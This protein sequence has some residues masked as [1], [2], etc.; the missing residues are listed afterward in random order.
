MER[1]KK[2][3]LPFLLLILWFPLQG[4]IAVEGDL[5]RY[6]LL[7]NG[8]EYEETIS[9]LNKGE[10]DATVKV[11]LKDYAIQPDGSVIYRDPEENERTNARWITFFP[12]NLVLRP[13]A[14]GEITCT[15]RVPDDESLKGTF[16]SML[17]IEDVPVA[18][19]L[20]DPEPGTLSIRQIFRFGVQ[21]I[22]D[23]KGSASPQLKFTGTGL[24]KNETGRFLNITIENPGE[25]WLTPQLYV[26]L[27]NDAG[28]FVRRFEG[29]KARLF[30]STSV[31][32]TIDISD[33]E[34]GTYRA[35]LIADCGDDLLFGG[36]Y[37]L[38]VGN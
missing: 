11:Y 32:R 12:E 7:S 38:K 13:G 26:E 36:K 29:E 21:I 28:E 35:L 4:Q 5:T 31:N 25:V 9:L 3:L 15:I 19:S 27:Y 20:Q 1:D 22:T 18:A 2:L 34:E 37:T 33:V 16:W 6:R 14:G 17:F 30:P 23:L 24:I 10:K 8:A